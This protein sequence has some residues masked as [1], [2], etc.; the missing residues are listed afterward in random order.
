VHTLRFLVIVSS[1]IAEA[2][3]QKLYVPQQRIVQITFKQ[4]GKLADLEYKASS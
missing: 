3:K 2:P 1:E 4:R